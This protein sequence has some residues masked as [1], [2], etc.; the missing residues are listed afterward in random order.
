M[1]LVFGLDVPLFELL[2]V[3]MVF[4]TAGLIFILLE[5]K[6]LNTYLIIER[7]DLR[8][9]ERDLHV[10]EHEEK[11]LDAD[12]RRLLDVPLPPKKRGARKKR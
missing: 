5:L 4:M 12:E 11:K 9:L 7:Q 6:R 1:V 8:R 3:F 10:L 2:L